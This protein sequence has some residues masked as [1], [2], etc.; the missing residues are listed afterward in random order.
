MKMH[1]CPV[2]HKEYE[3]FHPMGCNSSY[4]TICRECV[5][6]DACKADPTS[7]KVQQ[8]ALKNY[9]NE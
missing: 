7:K 5:E 6:E 1:K 2:C 4:L 8:Q 9:K 3:C